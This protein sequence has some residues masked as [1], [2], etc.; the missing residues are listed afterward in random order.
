MAKK[1]L[2]SRPKAVDAPKSLASTP[3]VEPAAFEAPAEHK[4]TLG[5]WLV[6]VALIIG[7]VVISL[8]VKQF[9]G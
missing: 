5:S 2:T 3:S 7:V 8:A 4:S 1:P 6:V 9:V